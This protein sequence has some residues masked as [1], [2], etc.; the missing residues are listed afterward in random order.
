[1]NEIGPI[2][3]T[4]MAGFLL[5]LFFFGGLWWTTRRG[6]RSKS[7]AL[8]FL[9]SWLIRLAITITGFY[10]ISRDHGERVLICLAGFLVARIIIMRLTQVREISP[11]Q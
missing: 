7:P 5:G 1:M 3:L 2:I 11:N 9:G 6:V 4:L 8:W 10:F